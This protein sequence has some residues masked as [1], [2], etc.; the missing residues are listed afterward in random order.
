MNVRVA[1]ATEAP[2][3]SPND[4][5]TSGALSSPA[6]ETVA[7]NWTASGTTPDVGLA[8]QATLRPPE[9]PDGD[10]SSSQ[11]ASPTASPTTTNQRVFDMRAPG[12]AGA[13]VSNPR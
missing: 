5:L 2:L 7:L 11:P 3:P 9:A 13:S 12:I 8:L 10:S 6:P 4:Q 1:V